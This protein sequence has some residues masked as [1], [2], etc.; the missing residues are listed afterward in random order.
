MPVR[1][2]VIRE[3]TWLQ[4]GNLDELL[5]IENL[6]N[7]NIPAEG[8][9]V[10]DVLRHGL[11]E[12]TNP[13]DPKT[14][15]GQRY[16]E[17]IMP[18][19]YKEVMDLIENNPRAALPE[20]IS[21]MFGVRI[22]SQDNHSAV[23]MKL[24]DFLPA[25]YGSTAMFAKELVEVAGSDFDIDKVYSLIKEFYVEDGVF[26]E[27]KNEYNDYLRYVSDKAS[28]AGT[29]YSEAL[30][31]YLNGDLAS[32]ISNTLTDAEQDIVTDAGLSESGL[33]AL[34][35]LGLPITKKQYDD[36]VKKHGAPFAAPLNLS[37]I[38]I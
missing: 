26:K 32:N 21:K 22:P 4:D 15:T 24:V 11:M 29:I 33:K 18:A 17:M 1:S 31:L 36:Y 12:Y 3:N 27:Y 8:V 30:G 25:Y 16:T 13:K 35:I 5:D 23:N 28:V 7:A 10:L 14:A 19:H 34:Q 37:L 2:E 20:V 38:H 6:T 9:V